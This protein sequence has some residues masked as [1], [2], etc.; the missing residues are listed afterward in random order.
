M[1][2][3][4]AAL[5]GGMLNE[6]VSGA[7]DL[8]AGQAGAPATGSTTANGDIVPSTNEVMLQR[9]LA[10]VMKP[11]YQMAGQAKEHE[12]RRIRETMFGIKPDA[13]TANPIAKG[14]SEFLATRLYNRDLQPYIK[15][16]E[17]EAKNNV[18]NS[19]AGEAGYGDQWKST[20]TSFIAHPD[21]EVNQYGNLLNIMSKTQDM[22]TKQKAQIGLNALKKRW[23]KTNQGDKLALLHQLEALKSTKGKSAD[24]G[25]VQKKAIRSMKTYLDSLKFNVGQDNKVRGY[26]TYPVNNAQMDA[27]NQE[28]QAV[29]I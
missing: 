20:I 26:K 24:L 6:Y 22:Q 19:S 17:E 29:K 12:A 27:A 5:L 23:V 2:D 14:V 18:R 28:A 21:A 3:K 8:A 16:M 11:V 9:R 10:D 15:A 1:Q 7:S 25:Q 13:P 4:L